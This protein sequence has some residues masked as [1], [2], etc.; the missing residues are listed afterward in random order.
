MYTHKCV[1]FTHSKRMKNWEYSMHVCNFNMYC[2]RCKLYIICIIIW[3]I[4]LLQNWCILYC[5]AKICLV[6][7]YMY[8]KRPGHIDLSFFIFYDIFQQNQKEFKL[9]F[10]FYEIITT[11]QK[12]N[13]FRSREVKIIF[14]YHTLKFLNISML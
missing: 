12:L 7:I 11:N 3:E 6:F 5:N 2:I 10:K 1:G 14:N 4:I 9:Q 13:K 8:R